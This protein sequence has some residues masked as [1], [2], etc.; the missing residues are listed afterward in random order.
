MF[1][2]VHGNGILVPSPP[3]PVKTWIH[4]HP[5]PQIF[6]HRRKDGSDSHR[7]GKTG[8]LL[9]IPHITNSLVSLYT[10][11]FISNQIIKPIVPILHQVDGDV[12][13]II[14]PYLSTPAVLAASL[15]QVHNYVAWGGSIRFPKNPTPPFFLASGSQRRG[16]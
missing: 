13:S 8:N 10:G 11:Q 14:R 12:I 5:S 6:C 1:R 9:K 4:P 3:I 15:G 7:S 2:G 16:V